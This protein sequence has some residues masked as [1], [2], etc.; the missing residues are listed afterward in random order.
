MNMNA[1]WVQFS[2]VWAY[3]NSREDDVILKSPP[4]ESK[5]ITVLSQLYSY[6]NFKKHSFHEIQ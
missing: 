2:N 1:Q 3:N 6:L 5:R 4:I